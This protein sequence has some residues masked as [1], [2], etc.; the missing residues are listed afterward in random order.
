V[1]VRASVTELP[2]EGAASE[3][4]RDAAAPATPPE[5]LDGR[6]AVVVGG[7]ASRALPL[8][9][10]SGELLAALEALPSIGAGGARVRRVW[11]PRG[12]VAGGSAWDITL[13]APPPGAEEGGGAL[14]GG[15]TLALLSA[16]EAAPRAREGALLL[17]DPTVVPVST[18]QLRAPAGAAA[19]PPR[20]AVRV[21]TRARGSGAAPAL[22][23]VETRCI[24]SE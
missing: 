22:A 9:V 7:A 21:E 16:S 17:A 15:A 3:R 4:E 8:D 18:L 10:T 1:T 19:A 2:D 24:P 14:N 12:D 11:G 20:F 6:F 13:L 23:H 5:A